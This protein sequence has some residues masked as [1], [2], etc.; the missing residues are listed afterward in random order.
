M[1]HKVLLH[2]TGSSMRFLFTVFLIIVKL[3]ITGKTFFKLLNARTKK[4]ELAD[5][6]NKYCFKFY[7]SFSWKGKKSS[8]LI[9]GKSHFM[10]SFSFFSNFLFFIIFL[11]PSCF[12]NLLPVY[13]RCI[14]LKT[15]TIFCKV[16]SW[17]TE[18]TYSEIKIILIRELVQF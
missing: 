11:S 16:G 8:Q 7:A 18:F 17:I 14:S 2:E 5:I 15:K 10:H 9:I 3:M 12:S 13:V 4:C 1:K 6:L